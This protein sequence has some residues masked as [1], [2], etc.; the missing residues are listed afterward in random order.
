M[1]QLSEEQFRIVAATFL[2]VFPR[3]TLWRGDF[4]TDTPTLALVGHTDGRDLD[5]PALDQR[6]ER[7]KPWCAPDTP[8]LC[9]RGGP[10]LFLVGPLDPADP[11]YATAR[12]NR[13][14]EPWVELLSPTTRP[15][16]GP[17]APSGFTGEALYD[18][19]ERVRTLPLNGSPLSALSPEHL[20][21][22]DA[23]AGLWGASLLLQEG[24]EEEANRRAAESLSSLPEELQSVIADRAFD[25]TPR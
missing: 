19:T 23:G 16:S 1:Y 14:S 3:A 5:A 7:W 6:V 21:W 24:R 22:R 25:R 2:D 15:Q 17:A 12:R 8:V 4:L 18:F 20:A 9:A 11:Q 13:E 10:W